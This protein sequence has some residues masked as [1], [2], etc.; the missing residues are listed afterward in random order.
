MNFPETPSSLPGSPPPRLSRADRSRR[1]R[2]AQLAVPQDSEGRAAL[3]A[4]LTHRSYPTYELFVYAAAC[5][6]LL[7]LGYFLDSQALLIFGILIAPLLLPWVGLLLA[8]VTGSLRF[9]FETLMALLLSAAIVFVIGL[10]SGFVARPFMPR[11]FNEAFLHSR[12]WWPDLLVL[13]IGAAILTVSFVRSESKPFLPNVMLAYEFFLPLAAGGFGLGAGLHE[14]WPFGVLVFFVHFAWAC[15]FGLLTL[16]ALR[17]MPSNLQGLVFSGAVAFV[18][19]ILLVVLM[20]GGNWS[21]TFALQSPGGTPTA[22]AN[23]NLPPDASAPGLQSSPTPLIETLT[24]TVS[25]TDTPSAAS[26]DVTETP[27]AS[28]TVTLTFEPTPVYAQVLA[29]RQGGAVL[30]DTP[31]GKGITVLDNFEYVQV[32]PETQDV[33]GYTWVHVIATHGGN[34]IEGWMAE[35]YLAQPT[36]VRTLVPAAS[37]TP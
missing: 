3:L 19:L 14:V 37:P 16:A 4:N 2:H 13:A 17:F 32:L 12:L 5:G 27:A 1:R 31:G 18:L 6:A 35:P 15:M 34:Q 26:S 20:S 9:F 30:R 25:L 21:P 28:P 24:P 8:T 10:L 33:D 29:P 23:A 11:T 22:A 36:P 7:G